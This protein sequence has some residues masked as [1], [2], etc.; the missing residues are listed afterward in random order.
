MVVGLFV[1]VGSQLGGLVVGLKVG[2]GG[3][4]VTISGCSS[5]VS[6]SSLSVDEQRAFKGQS[7]I[8]LSCGRESL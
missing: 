7:Q 3:L 5:G 4:L 1:V 2:R 8:C 6:K